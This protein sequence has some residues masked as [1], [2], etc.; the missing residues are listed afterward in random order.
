MLIVTWLYAVGA[1]AIALASGTGL[2]GTSR[3]WWK[4][5]AVLTAGVAV[6]ILLVN[7]TA[8]SASQH[9]PIRTFISAVLVYPAGLLILG[10]IAFAARKMD[11]ARRMYLCIGLVVPIYLTST[12]AGVVMGCEANN[13]EVFRTPLACAAPPETASHATAFNVP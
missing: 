8:W 9:L 2:L 12:V 4:L 13:K 1:L 11:R 5:V 6:Q 10:G 7:T 3:N